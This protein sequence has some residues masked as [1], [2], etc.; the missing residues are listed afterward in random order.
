MRHNFETDYAIEH[1]KDYL[2]KELDTDSVTIDEYICDVGK[3][4]DWFKGSDRLVSLALHDYGIS[5]ACWVQ[6][7]MDGNMFPY[8]SDVIDFAL[9]CELIDDWSIYWEL[10]IRDINYLRY[11]I[12]ICMW[13]AACELLMA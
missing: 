11:Q 9:E 6:W 7:V 10:M 8:T 4:T 12:G 3:M 1:C 13:R 2:I 5:C